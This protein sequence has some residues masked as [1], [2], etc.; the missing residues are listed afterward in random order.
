MYVTVSSALFPT[1]RKNQDI[2][3]VQSGMYSHGY[4]RLSVNDVM[5]I[6]EK[7]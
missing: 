1:Y 6:L 7:E 5:N 4:K 2:K 3:V